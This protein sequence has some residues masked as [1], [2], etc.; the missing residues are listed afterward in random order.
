MTQLKE[1]KKYSSTMVKLCSQLIKKKTSLR[2]HY[3]RSNIK[4]NMLWVIL[5]SLFLKGKKQSIIPH[6]FILSLTTKLLNSVSKHELRSIKVFKLGCGLF[7]FSLILI[8]FCYG[9]T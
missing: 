8:F 1:H 4:D 3:I 5:S 2:L 9:Y 6:I 7:F